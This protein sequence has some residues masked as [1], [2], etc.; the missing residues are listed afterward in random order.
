MTDGDNELDRTLQ[1]AAAAMDAELAEALDVERAL[2]DLH[3]EAAGR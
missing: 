1:R 2:A 3:R